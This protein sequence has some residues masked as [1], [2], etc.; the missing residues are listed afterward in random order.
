MFQNLKSQGSV[1][2]FLDQVMFIPFVS[3]EIYHNAAWSVA[4]GTDRGYVSITDERRG[5]DNIGTGYIQ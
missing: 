4:A 5:E 2:S 1:S 3:P